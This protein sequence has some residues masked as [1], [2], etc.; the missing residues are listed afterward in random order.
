MNERD[1][2][3]RALAGAA[4]N[5]Q[6]EL[7]KFRAA[8]G[9]QRDARWP[10]GATAFMMYSVVALLVVIEGALN[11]GFFAHGLD[12]GWLGGLSYAVGLA[13][14]NVVI[15]FGWGKYGVRY[16]LHR[17][18]L[19][20]IG[21]LLAIALAFGLIVGLGLG[22]AHFRDSLLSQ[23]VDPARAAL[24][25]FQA[26]PFRLRDIMSW[27]L[28]FLSTF[29]GMV[30]LADG[31]LIEDRY[32]GYG[33]LSRQTQQIIEDYESELED[34]REELETLKGDELTRLDKVVK[35]AQATM[36][37]YKIRIDEKDAAALRLSTALQ[38]AENA[39]AALLG[40]FRSEN[41][42]HRG[43]LARPRY[44]DQQPPL[45]QLP[46][47]DF[48]TEEDR[49]ELTMQGALVE[50]LV[51][52]VQTIRARIQEALSHKYDILKPLGTHYRTTESN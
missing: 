7:E 43:G 1:T 29:F 25:A 20:K 30:A 35:S 10:V 47:P 19:I 48:S 22:I 42:L 4:R 6:I 24:D 46:F 44:F 8:H 45:R 9:L 21:G 31:F 52:D 27:G 3:L 18:P 13:L 51:G 12:S 41:E 37:V 28:F 50:R 5:A 15:A 32:P 36:A 34:L 11:A 26:H 16:V 38:N 2:E 49:N 33:K 17:H 40:H 23:A 39:V 14:V